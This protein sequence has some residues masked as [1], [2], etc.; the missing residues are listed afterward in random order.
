MK[1]KRHN[2]IIEIVEN[3]N[4]D[5]QQELID[6]LRIAGYDVTQATISRDIRE[7]KLLKVMSDTGT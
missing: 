4:I 2:K 6:K 7:L 3:S 5:T 1:I